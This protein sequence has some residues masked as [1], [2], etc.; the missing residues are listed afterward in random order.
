V[1]AAAAWSLAGGAMIVLPPIWIAATWLVMTTRMFM[2]GTWSTSSRIFL[3]PAF[4]SDLILGYAP[5]FLAGV[6]LL[7][8]RRHVA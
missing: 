6:T 5:W 2:A 8:L 1:P 4:Y 7:L 3:E